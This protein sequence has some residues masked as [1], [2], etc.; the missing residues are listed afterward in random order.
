MSCSRRRTGGSAPGCERQAMEAP[1]RYSLPR[2][3]RLAAPA[4]NARPVT[5]AGLVGRSAHWS[6]CCSTPEAVTATGLPL[7]AERGSPIE[8]GRWATRRKPG[9]IV[10]DFGPTVSLGSA[11]PWTDGCSVS[12][13]KAGAAPVAAECACRR[14]SRPPGEGHDVRN[15]SRRC[16]SPAERQL[17]IWA[18]S[19]FLCPGQ[20]RAESGAT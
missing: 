18:E 5:V 14:A 12:A 11:S 3:S 10:A 9:P 15:S 17:T 8:T 13:R 19:A 4:P 1:R 6:C 20:H 16:S 7:D 2:V